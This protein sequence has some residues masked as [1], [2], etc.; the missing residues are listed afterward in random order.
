MSTE[1]NVDLV[2]VGVEFVS[3]PRMLHGLEVDLGSAA[4][5]AVAAE[6][7]PLVDPEQVF[8]VVSQ[9][10][11]HLAVAAACRVTENDHDIFD[12]PFGTAIVG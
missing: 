7:V 8:A 4:D 9:R 12:S 6:T 1:R 2:F 3:L 5:V 11:C 10:C